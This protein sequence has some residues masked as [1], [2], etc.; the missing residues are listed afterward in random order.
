M[1]WQQWTLFHLNSVLF[2]YLVTL[3]SFYLQPKA[4]IGAFQRNRYVLNELIYYTFLSLFASESVSRP[5]FV[6]IALEKTLNML[7]V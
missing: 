5:I 4:E 3:Q 1:Y 2:T 6:F 7:K